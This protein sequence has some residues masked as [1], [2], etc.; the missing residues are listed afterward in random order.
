MCRLCRQER[1]RL[2]SSKPPHEMIGQ[3]H[4]ALILV[5]TCRVSYNL[6]AQIHTFFALISLLYLFVFDLLTSP[7]FISIFSRSD[8][9]VRAIINALLRHPFFNAIEKLAYSMCK[10]WKFSSHPYITMMHCCSFRF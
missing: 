1:A 10:S 9:T 8:T 3:W 2:I 6:N 7:Y 4:N 5:R